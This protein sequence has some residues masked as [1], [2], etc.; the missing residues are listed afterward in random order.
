M[1]TTA[2]KATKRK[3]PKR[4]TLVLSLK[5]GDHERLKAL[6]EKNSRRM[7]DMA[8]LIVLNTISPNRA[9]R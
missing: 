2:R 6:A 5:D 8:R 4:Y 7:T 3:E 9:E 1:P